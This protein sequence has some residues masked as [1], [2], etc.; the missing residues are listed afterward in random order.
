MRH[1][2]LGRSC[3]ARL[4]AAG[5]LA[6][7]AGCGTR[8]YTKLMGSRADAVRTSAPFR[9]LFRA[10]QLPGTPIKIRVPLIFTK[11]YAEGSE[12]P[13]DK[14]K[15]APDRLQPPFLPLP[16]FKLCY[17]GMADDPQLGAKAPFYCYLAALPAKPGDADKMAADLQAQLKAKFKET[18][19]EWDAL[20]AL[21]PDG[22]ALQWKKIRVVAEQP[23]RVRSGEQ[24]A[25]KNVPG[26]FE[27]WLYDAHEYIVLVGWRAPSSIEGPSG[28]GATSQKAGLALPTET[29]PDLQGMPVLTAGTLTID[30]APAADAPSP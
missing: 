8:E 30:A 9:T 23:F 11:S 19:A 2:K 18:P 4:G 12:H 29:K 10:S 17:E 20:D 5:L 25:S 28:S 24:V 21:T 16:G 7:L 3:R 15:I 6:L 27:L 14:G 26:I 1:H 13:D 22:K